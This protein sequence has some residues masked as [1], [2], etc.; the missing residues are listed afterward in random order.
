VIVVH[1]L[2]HAEAALAAAAA[3]GVPV[4]LASAPDAGGYGGAL[5][6]D[7]LVALARQAHPAARATALLDCGDRP[8]L[9]LA[10]LRQGIDQVRF[11]G[12]AR[13]A[14]KL[15]ELATA[16]GAEI[17]RGRLAALDLL[18]IDDP[19]AACRAYLAGSTGPGR[20]R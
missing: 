4:T 7:R 17:R 10:A 16:Q 1:G 18:D 6:F 3:L 19:A 2:A 12:S 14:G 15:T 20:R 11:T 13:V 9:V 8:G 5:W